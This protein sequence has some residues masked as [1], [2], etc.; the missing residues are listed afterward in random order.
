MMIHCSFHLFDTNS[1]QILK[2]GAQ[3]SVKLLIHFV[4]YFVLSW[5]CF[6]VNNIIT[7]MVMTSRS[8]YRYFSFGPIE[9]LQL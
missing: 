8:N 9:L 6:L 4:C 3:I 1:L 5:C 7:Q 2:H